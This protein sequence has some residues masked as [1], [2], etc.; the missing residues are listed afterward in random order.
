M[1]NMSYC[2]FENTYNDLDQCY[3]ALA[4]AIN[5]GSLR[6]FLDNMSAEERWAFKRMRSL[7]NDMVEAYDHVADAAVKYGVDLR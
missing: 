5:E 1:A 4:E 3:E 7:V 2:M 6:E